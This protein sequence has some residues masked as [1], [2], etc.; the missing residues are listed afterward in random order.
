MFVAADTQCNDVKNHSS[1]Q[2]DDEEYLKPS[3]SIIAFG[4]NYQV[5]QKKNKDKWQSLAKYQRSTMFKIMQI[6][7][8]TM[9]L[10]IGLGK[11]F[12]SKKIP[13]LRSH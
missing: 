6:R 11:N 7:I 5:L 8:G 3:S 9:T 10:Q 2:A 12:L 4:D 13:C 1:I